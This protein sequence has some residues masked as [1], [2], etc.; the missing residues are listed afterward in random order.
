MYVDLIEKALTYVNARYPQSLLA[1]RQEFFAMTGEVYE[2]DLFFDERVNNYLEWFLFA[3][4]FMTDP[5]AF[6]FY[7]REAGPTLSAADQL[8][9][10]AMREPVH[11]LFEVIKIAPK[12]NLIVL[13]SLLDK[14][15][16]FDISERRNPVGLNKGEIIETR[17]V[18]GAEATHFLNAFVV[19]PAKA[20]K[21]I[22]KRIK[23][24][25]KEGESEFLP[26]F[27][28]LQRLWMQCRRYK[29]VNPTRIYSEENVSHFH[30]R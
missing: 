3:R 24:M 5:N 2:D 7:A 27:M 15:V 21:F 8:T 12:K 28:L 23:Q 14:K 13:R 18:A 6:A 9:L 20:G 22:R 1:A 19:H 29:H 4:P 25:Q 26:F 17:L 10:L 16:K 30:A 11:G